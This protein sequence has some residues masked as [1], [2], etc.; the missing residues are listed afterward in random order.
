MT[1]GLTRRATFAAFAAPVLL[2][3]DAA[4]PQA[5]PTVLP[6]DASQ[7]LSF[8][9]F[10]DAPTIAAVQRRGAKIDVTAALQQAIDEAFATGT[11]LHLPAGAYRI[12]KTIELNRGNYAFS[13][14]I[15]GENGNSTRIYF[16][17]SQSLADM[18]AIGPGASY[19]L[20]K[21]LEFIDLNPRTS[22]CFHFDDDATDRGWPSWKHTFS[23]VR[24]VAFREGCRFDGDRNESE[25][26]FLQSKFRNCATSLAYNNR[27]AVNHQLIGTDFENDDPADVREKWPLISFE[28]GAFVNHVG[29]SAIGYGPYIR[30]AFPAD[31]TAFQA[32]SQF[33]SEGVRL[34]ARGNGPFIYHDESSGIVHSNVFR[35]LFNGM[36]VV[37]YG[38]SRT[39]ALAQFGGR[40]LAV[41]E[42]CDT[43]QPMTIDAVV[44][45]DLA[46]NGAYGAIFLDRCKGIEYNR[47]TK[48]AYGSGE[49][50]RS[51][52][53]AIPAEISSTSESAGV[54][55]GAD[56]YVDL[57]SSAQTIY[58]GGWQIAQIKTLTFASKQAG[59]GLPS[60][61]VRMPPNAR[62][63]KL[64]LLREE[65]G[66]AMTVRLHVVARGTDIP[67]ADIDLPPG[68]TGHFEANLQALQGM[69]LLAGDKWDGSVK[70]VSTGASFDGLAMI[71]YM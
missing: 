53:A 65:A 52:R 30:Y 33:R 25:I 50:S 10:L 62:P 43:N 56:G 49:V 58:S 71:D 24:V 28:R 20:A 60:L 18:F 61:L 23:N 34:E 41:F 37:G 15:E 13:A 46:A 3:N 12:T 63:C 27:Q 39:P 36:S 47:V 6:G 5:R 38:S 31:P 67:I 32:T 16:D 64:R 44:T 57:L 17:N 45:A 59:A 7:R 70:L 35:L 9:K 22:R 14:G 55:S 66:P 21:D 8:F 1:D 4:P 29:G 42:N 40:T 54:A 51:S 11:V 19:F 26:M 69:S 48:A 68:V 2:G